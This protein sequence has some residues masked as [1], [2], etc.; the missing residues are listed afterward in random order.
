VL[1]G[2]VDAAQTLPDLAI[3]AFGTPALTALDAAEALAADPEAPIRV[4]VFDARFA[5]PL[6]TALLRNILSRGIPLVTIED[7]SIIGGFGSA[8][9]EAA[10]EM[11]LD[12]SRVMRLGLP[13][14][15]IYQDSRSKQLAEVGLDKPGLIRAIRQALAQTP[16]VGERASIADGRTAASSRPAPPSHS[17][18]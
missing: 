5:K 10:Q 7:H 11:G 2:A 12:A 9:L 1:P 13:D 18:R 4:A 17:A 16:G 15:W 8:V 3:L 14:S 6:D